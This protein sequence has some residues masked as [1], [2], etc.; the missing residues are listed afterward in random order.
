MFDL[1]IHHLRFTVE[2]TTPIRLDEYKGSALRGAWHTYL[3]Q[4]YCGAPPAAREDPLHQAMCP[5]CFLTNRETGSETR[6]PYALQPP[7]SRQLEYA[8]GERF[9]FGISLFGHAHTLF[10]YALLA[11][12]EM[13][14]GEGVGQW[15]EGGKQRGKY[16]LVQ[17]EAYDPHSGAAQT[18]LAEG[19]KMVRMPEVAVTASSIARRAETLDEAIAAQSGQLLLTLLTPLR[20]IHHKRLMHWFTFS[21]F[22]QRLAERLFELAEQ[23]GAAGGGVDREALRQEVRALLPLAEQV[24][25]AG[26]DTVWWDVTGYSRRKEGATYLGGLVGNVWLECADWRPFLPYLLWGQSVQVGKN[27]VKGGGWFTVDAAPQRFEDR[28]PDAEEGEDGDY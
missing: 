13:G 24:A 16:R 26:H 22:F 28:W 12:R 23:F 4:A 6:R 21:F 14:E 9:Q 10:P 25:V 5:V 17:V 8:P 2:A 11:V 18:L 7:L 20:L 1:T 3:Q 27:V 19:E 15:L